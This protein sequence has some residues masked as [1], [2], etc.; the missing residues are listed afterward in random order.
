M[1]NKTQQKEHWTYY[2]I[3]TTNIY[4]K[5]VDNT[6][7]AGTKY[8]SYYLYWNHDNQDILKFSVPSWDCYIVWDGTNRYLLMRVD[9]SNTNE[10]TIKMVQQLESKQASSKV[11][12]FSADYCFD[13]NEN[14]CEDY[15]Y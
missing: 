15:D 4:V 10:R 6:S 5:L 13:D 12:L 1:E 3:N 9:K 14:D 11:R 2:L 7:K 8:K